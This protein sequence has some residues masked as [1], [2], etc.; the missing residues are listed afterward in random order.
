MTGGVEKLRDRDGTAQRAPFGDVAVPR[1]GDGWKR[2][3]IE[4]VLSV[5]HLMSLVPIGRSV[6]FSGAALAD[7]VHYRAA[8]ASVLGL[9]VVQQNFNFRDGVQTH[10]RRVRI[11]TAVILPLLTVDADGE[12]AGAHAANVRQSRADGARAVKRLRFPG[13]AYS[14]KQSQEAHDVSSAL[15]NAFQLLRREN[16]GTFGTR[17]LHHVGFGADADGLGHGAYAQLDCAE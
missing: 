10:R 16:G 15:G 9:I 7:D 17:R 13:R 6:E 12:G 2:G 4:E 8:V 14:G 3:V 5:E 1:L 11:R